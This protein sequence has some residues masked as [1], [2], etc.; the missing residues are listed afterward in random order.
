MSKIP[1]ELHVYVQDKVFDQYKK[2][3]VEFEQWKSKIEE[4]GKFKFPEVNVDNQT[5]LDDIFQEGKVSEDW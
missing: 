2:E 4:E 3:M 1:R 5:P